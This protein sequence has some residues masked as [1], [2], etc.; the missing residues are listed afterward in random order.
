MKFKIGDIVQIKYRPSWPFSINNRNY[1]I[2]AVCL[3]N[4]VYQLQNTVNDKS[5]LKCVLAED[6]FKVDLKEYLS[7]QVIES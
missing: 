5:P 3:G 6:I 2:V 7:S 4:D 1:Y